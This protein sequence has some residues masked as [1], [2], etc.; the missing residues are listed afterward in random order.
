MRTTLTLETDAF[1]LAQTYA[2][3]R[4]LKLGQ[5]V[6]ELIRLAG[7]ERLGTRVRNGVCVFDLPPDTPQVS[8][9]QVQAMLDELS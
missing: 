7:R 6:S 9:A 4:A 1:E 3:A 5:A 8:A 2:Q